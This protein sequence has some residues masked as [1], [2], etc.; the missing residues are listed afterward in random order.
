[1]PQPLTTKEHFSIS[2]QRQLSIHF[3]LWIPA[4][5]QEPQGLF[6]LSAEQGRVSL[7][8]VVLERPITLGGPLQLEEWRQRSVCSIDRG[9]LPGEKAETTGRTPET[10]RQTHAPRA[11]CL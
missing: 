9:G 4:L 1:M 5:K 2:G 6:C 10:E 8:L 7:G 11:A 3:L